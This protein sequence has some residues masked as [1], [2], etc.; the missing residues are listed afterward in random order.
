MLDRVAADW[1]GL[2]LAAAT[3]V[4]VLITCYMIVQVFN[5]KR[6]R[7]PDCK[8]FCETANNNTPSN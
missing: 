2:I 3:L 7:P 1:N 6:P 5:A 4:L 8:T